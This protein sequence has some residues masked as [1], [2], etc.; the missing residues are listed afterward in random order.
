MATSRQ[1]TLTSPQQKAQNAKARQAKKAEGQTPKLCECS[2]GG[3]TVRQD[4]SFI[5]GHDQRFK[6]ILL[7]KFDEGD[8]AAAVELVRRGWKSNDDLEARADRRE[9]AQKD[10]EARQAERD[11]RAQEREAERFRKAE[12][13][14][15]AAEARAKGQPVE[16]AA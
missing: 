1:T 5:S 10:R 11:A 13:K 12:A 9:K 3:Y 14:R 16:A 15:L 2:C 7:R 6:G 4:A 8:E